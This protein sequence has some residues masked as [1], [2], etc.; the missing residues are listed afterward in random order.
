MLSIPTLPTL[1]FKYSYVLSLI[2]NKTFYCKGQ[3]WRADAAFLLPSFFYNCP[4]YLNLFRLY[5]LP[6]TSLYTFRIC[7]TVV[8]NL[9]IITALILNRRLSRVV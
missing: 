8:K 1:Y 6:C 3:T 2:C 7:S 4:S 5:L 9:M